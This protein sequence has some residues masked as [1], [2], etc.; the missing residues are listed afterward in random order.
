MVEP[1]DRT[2]TIESGLLFAWVANFG[3]T[4][5]GESQDR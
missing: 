5:T 3:Q 2:T 4:P 1:L